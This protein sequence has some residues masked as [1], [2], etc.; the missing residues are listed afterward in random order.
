MFGFK[1]KRSSSTSSSVSS[2]STGYSKN[3]RNR[4]S[5]VTV[6]TTY[7]VEEEE[8][9]E[10]K[11]VPSRPH[12]VISTGSTVTTDSMKVHNRSNSS[13]TQ[14]KRKSLYSADLTEEER[15]SL[16]RDEIQRE[17]MSLQRLEQLAQALPKIKSR[18]A[19]TYHPSSNDLRGN[20]EFGAGHSSSSVIEKLQQS[21]DSLKRE[22]REQQAIAN[23]ERHTTDAVRKRCEHL[24]TTIEVLRHE[25]EML[26]KMLDRKDRK[27]ETLEDANERSNK[28]LAEYKEADQSKEKDART[29]EGKIAALT[30]ENE[31]IK[32][33]YKEVI[34]STQ[35]VKDR[36]HQD[37]M[38]IKEKIEWIKN[39]REKDSENRGILE[40][41]IQEQVL[42]KKKLLQLNNQANEL[43]QR[44]LKQLEQIF[45]DMRQVVADS[46]KDV[47]RK[48]KNTLR[49]I[50][51]LERQYIE[52]GGDR[53][54][55]NYRG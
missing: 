54:N 23:E 52:L 22:L 7:T 6:N 4:E 48:V 21:V 28:Q 36:C 10:D 49:V 39:E 24:E 50:D 16:L 27:I 31:H 32:N 34:K 55:L 17:S 15:A 30:E 37:I 26:H 29:Y 12:S 11:E 47:S 51:K 38:F 46:D 53:R 20:Y 9:L 5:V 45:A 8:A 1:G 35:L 19:S 3:N 13:S 43:R 14:G 18:H 2:S 40:V 42:E 25:N 33:A 44:H 41:K